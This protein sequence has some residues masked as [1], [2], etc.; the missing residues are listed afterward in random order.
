MIHLVH[1]ASLLL[2]LL[3]SI[4]SG[5]LWCYSCVSNQPGCSENYVNWLIQSAIT[6]PKANDK[7]VKIIESTGADTLVTRDCLSNLEG[8]RSDIPGDKY[9]GCRPAAS[10][11]KSAI[12]VENNVH[13]L[14]LRGQHRANVTWCFCEFD[15]WCNGSPHLHH[16]SLLS[17]LMISLLTVTATSFAFGHAY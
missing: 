16:L 6:C 3:P 1:F 9:E 17:T 14:H 11:P 5:N 12:Y 13:E 15:E 4:V 8:I 10:S 2:A 7:C